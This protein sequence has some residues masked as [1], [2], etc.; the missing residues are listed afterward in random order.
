MLDVRPVEDGPEQQQDGRKSCQHQ[1]ETPFLQPV[2]TNQTDHGSRPCA[3]RQHT[4]QHR[5][6]KD[7]PVPIHLT[8]V[9]GG[10]NPPVHGLQPQNADQHHG[11][12]GPAVTTGQLAD[13][14]VARERDEVEADAQKNGRTDQAPEEM[15]KRTGWRKSERPWRGHQRQ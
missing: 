11:H 2:L 8:G 14:Y 4:Q 5:R 1:H 3:A 13:R 15:A 9:G 7:E 10:Q 6:P 12:A